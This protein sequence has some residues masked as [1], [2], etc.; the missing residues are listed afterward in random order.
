MREPINFAKYRQQELDQN[1][2]STLSDAMNHQIISKRYAL[3]RYLGLSKDE[4]AQNER[5]LAQERGIN[6]NDPEMVK[7]LYGMNSSDFGGDFGNVGGDSSLDMTAE[8]SETGEGET[9]P[10]S[11]EPPTETP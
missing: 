10:A 1:Q 7:K 9:P 2:L 3:N 8:T 6:S 4:I 11:G 5:L